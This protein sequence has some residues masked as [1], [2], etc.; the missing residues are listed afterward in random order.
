M[1][2]HANFIK[3]LI[4]PLIRKAARNRI[5]TAKTWYAQRTGVLPDF[6]VVGSQKCGTT[7][8]YHYL[9]NSPAFHFPPKEIGFF[10]HQINDDI[11]WFR[12]QFP[13]V[14]KKWQSRFILKKNFIAGDVDPAYILDPHA[15]QRISDI[16]PKA[17]IILLMRNPVDRAYSHYHHC[18]RDGVENL[19]FE[20]ALK[21][22][23]ER[24]SDQWEKMLSGEKYDGV[25]IYRYSYLATGTYVDQVKDLLSLFD[26]NRI[27]FLEAENFF[28][29]PNAGI[30]TI[31][32]FLNLPKW[33]LARPGVH[34]QGKYQDMDIR[35]REKL[36][37]HFRP[38]NQRLYDLVGKFDWDR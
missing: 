37:D 20:D 12:G 35:L 2:H 38:F 14:V 23:P 32:N 18:V 26:R 5:K 16:I 22:E 1:D 29:N 24:I 17:K 10:T 33:E 34:N 21:A 30:Q 6:I 15:L 13:S 3:P 4:P 31:L 25:Q 36:I 8:V 19:S 27:L 28:R 9:K 11:F 7:S